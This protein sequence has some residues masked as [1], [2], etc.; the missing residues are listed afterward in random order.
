MPKEKKRGD[1]VASSRSQ[2]ATDENSKNKQTGAQAQDEF[3][4]L[5]QNLSNKAGIKMWSEPD[6]NTFNNI[7]NKKDKKKMN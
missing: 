6:A 5:M 3:T 2:R 4:K 7:F 1:S